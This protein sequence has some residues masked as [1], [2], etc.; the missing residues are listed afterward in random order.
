M[1]TAHRLNFLRFVYV[2]RYFDESTFFPLIVLLLSL[3][4]VSL[5]KFKT[6]QVKFMCDVHMNC[7]LY[8]VV[9]IQL[10]QNSTI[11]TRIYNSNKTG[12][13]NSAAISRD[14]DLACRSAENI[15][16]HLMMTIMMVE[17]LYLFLR[18]HIHKHLF[19]YCGFVYVFF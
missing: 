5:S 16:C 7:L 15:M 17:F 11:Y 19:F 6:I 2:S 12:C 13:S 1:C 3:L 8:I 18:S 9:C 4:F 10:K 14:L